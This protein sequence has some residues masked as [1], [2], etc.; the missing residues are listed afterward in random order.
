MER[1]GI[2]TGLMDKSGNEILSG[3]KV[4]IDPDYEGV[5]LYHRNMRCFGL[6]FG[7]WYGEENP[8]DPDCY[9]KLIPIPKDNGMRME[10]EVWG[11]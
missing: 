1:I 5:V 9:G 3:T 2:P 8:L 7:L 4:H 10:I 6:F 11:T